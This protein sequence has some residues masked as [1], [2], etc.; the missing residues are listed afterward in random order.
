VPLHVEAVLP[1]GAYGVI[2]R[3]VLFVVDAFEGVRARLALFCF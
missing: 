1:E 2:G 3:V